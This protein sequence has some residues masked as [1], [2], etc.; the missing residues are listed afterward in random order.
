MAGFTGHVQSVAGTVSNT[1]CVRTLRLRDWTPHRTR[2]D[3]EKVGGIEEAAAAAGRRRLRTRV[4]G[5]RVEGG[6]AQGSREQDVVLEPRGREEAG[7]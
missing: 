4:E 3:N 1:R 7:V 6:C 2:A 5:G